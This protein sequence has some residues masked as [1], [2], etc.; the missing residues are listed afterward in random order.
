[1]LLP[2]DGFGKSPGA[3]EKGGENSPPVIKKGIV[4]RVD[5]ARINYFPKS[6]KVPLVLE[7]SRK[8]RITQAKFELQVDS[9]AK[10][11]TINEWE[12]KLNLSV[13]FAIR[14]CRIY[15]DSL[16]GQMLE[17]NETIES[18]ESLY[19]GY[20]YSH[21]LSGKCSIYAHLDKR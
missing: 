18:N 21:L 15:L 3:G 19:A 11:M 2:P 20:F 10:R 6:I 7:S 5:S 16:D 8:K 13:P 12:D 1:M 9:E 14:D 4:F 17:L